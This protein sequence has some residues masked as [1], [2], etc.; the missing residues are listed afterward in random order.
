MW[1]VRLALARPYTFIVLAMVIVLLT[2]VVLMRTP[3]DIFPE[4]N[5]PVISLVWTYTGLQPHE[6]EQRITSNVERGLTTL[7]NDVE[8]IESQSLNGIAVIKVFFQPHANIQTA[9]AQTAAI[10]QTFLRFLPPGTTPPLVII[11]SASTVPVIQI[12]LT[13]DTMSEQQLFD[14]GNYFIRTQLATIPGAATPFPYGGKQRVISVDI[15]A[16]SLQS[17]GLSAVDIVNAVNAQNLILPTGTAKLGSLEY[18][19]E[20]NGSPKSVAELNDLPVKTVNGAT[21]YMRDVA[22]IRDGFSPQTNAVLAN[23]QRGVLMSIYKTGNASTLDIVDRV[24]AMLVYN[25][26]SYPQGLKV[27]QFFD[28]SLFVRASIQGVL[29]E[30][31]IAA[32][33]T[34]FMILLFLGN[35]KSTIIIAISI[36]LSILVSILLLSALGETINIM[37]LGGLAL[38]VGIL[39][40]DATGEL[41]NI[42]RNLAMGKET[43]QAILDGAQQIAVPAFVS[44]I[45]ICI[46]FIPMFFLSGVAKFLFVPLAEAVIFAMLASY[47]WSRTI[48]PTMAMYLLSAEDEYQAD[49]HRGEK[50]GL[51]RRYQ[52]AF[53]H[54]FER[55]RFGYR[56]ALTSALQHSRLFAAWFLAFC[57][58]SAGLTFVLG[59]DFFPSV[60]A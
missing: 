53:E 45:C 47:M 26:G 52:Q 24:K 44:T 14:F 46:V 18:N 49:L 36:P 55:F 60:D 4:I 7:V 11:Y 28:Q 58:A 2:P 37:T 5:I 25:A 35:W 34:A 32:V 15:D 23:G 19:V 31:L 13:S 59:R 6:M 22:H 29:R 12:G 9:L 3:T 48:V 43:V 8:H 1:I 42:N 20:M 17:K 30:A 51:F 50:L 33:L 54:G 41:E 40:D 38:A 27:S 56:R 10:S 39:V 21:I 57:V 16:A